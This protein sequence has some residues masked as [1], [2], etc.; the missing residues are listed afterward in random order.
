MPSCD[1]F[2]LYFLQFNSACQK[3]QLM[4][5][6]VVGSDQLKDLN[7]CF[8]PDKGVKLHQ[9]EVVFNEFQQQKKCTDYFIDFSLDDDLVSDDSELADRFVFKKH[10]RL[11]HSID[12][13]T[14]FKIS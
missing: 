2:G 13:N 7:S 14:R 9:M 11:S 3:N 4:A 10:T 12:K 1:S 6:C 5:R 8:F